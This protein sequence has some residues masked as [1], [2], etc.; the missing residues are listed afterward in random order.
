[1]NK[2]ATY[3]RESYK[4]LMEKVTWPTWAATSAIN[5]DRN[6]SNNSYYS[7]G[8]GHGLYNKCDI[9]IHL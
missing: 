2:I 6:C 8:C 7:A 3:F 5:H 4:E 1:M 9:E